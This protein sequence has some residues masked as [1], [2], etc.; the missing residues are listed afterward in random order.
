MFGYVEGLPLFLAYFGIGILLLAVFGFLYAAATPHQEMTLIRAGNGAAV[1]GL[2]G[3]VLG[4]SLPLAS[5]AAN[6]VSILDFVIW[7]VIGG[8]VQVLAFFVASATMTDLSGRITRGEMPAGAWAGGVGIGGG[9]AK[10]RLHDVLGVRAV[11]PSLRSRPSLHRRGERSSGGPRA[12]GRLTHRSRSRDMAR[13]SG[14]GRKLL[15]FGTIA[16]GGRA[17]GLRGAAALGRLRVPERRAVPGGR[18]RALGLRNQAERGHPAPCAGGAQV[19]LARGLRGAIRRG[20]LRRRSNGG[21][22]ARSSRRS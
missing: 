5:A 21:G 15:A 7:A 22:A 12:A 9:D 3:A 20:Q 14:S 2:L 16:A 11:G 13:K 18:L 19:R 17:R 6:S 10:R 4:F 8:V 1:L